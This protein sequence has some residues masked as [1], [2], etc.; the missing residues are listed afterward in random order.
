MSEYEH[1][2]LWNIYRILYKKSFNI[3]FYE[4][5]LGHAFKWAYDRLY[6]VS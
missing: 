5:S 3:N 4:I 2:L 6:N 1:A